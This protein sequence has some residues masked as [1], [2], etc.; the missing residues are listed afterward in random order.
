MVNEVSGQNMDWFFEQFFYSSNVADYEV[1]D[2]SSEA[3]EGKVGVY[4]EDGK[5]NTYLERDAAK[6]AE[7]SKGQLFRSTVVV[8][9]RGEALAGCYW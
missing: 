5:R 1:S 8:R 4:D 2:L 7:E 6:V 9:R 3:L